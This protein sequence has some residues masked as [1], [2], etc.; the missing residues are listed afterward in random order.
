MTVLIDLLSGAIGAIIII[1]VSLGL[2]FVRK[3][4]FK[5]FETKVDERANKAI[6]D[7]NAKNDTK[8]HTSKVLFELEQQ[9][10]N[11]NVIILGKLL[12]IAIE[13]SGIV[14]NDY[15]NGITLFNNIEYYTNQ[16]KKIYEY[17]AKYKTE[18]ILYSLYIP[19]EIDLLLNKLFATYKD[20]HLHI[21]KET[22]NNNINGL[23]S[24]FN[25]ILLQIEEENKLL[26][27]TIRE[28]Y[29]NIKIV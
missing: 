3:I 19:E 8:I 10:I 27:N 20:I 18:N 1:V 6:S 4:I 9:A 24:F 23:H 17:I 14:V 2:P 26:K 29:N 16:N 21:A 25:N 7:H 5:L 12:K 28:H 15:N 11:N 13:T 22:M